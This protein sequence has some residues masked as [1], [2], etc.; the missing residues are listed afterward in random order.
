MPKLKE[1]LRRGDISV[2]TW[3]TIGHPDVVEALSTLPLDWLVFDMEHAPLDISLLEIMIMGTRGSNVEPIVR[4]SWNDM[5]AIKR[6]LDLGFRGLMIPYVNTREEAESAVKYSRYPPKGV[7]GYGPRRAIMYGAYGAQSSLEYYRGF[8]KEL[9]LI[10]QIE[11]ERAV[12]QAEDIASVDGV[13]VLFVGPADLSISLSAPLDYGSPRFVDALKEV[14]RACEKQGKIP[15]IH[16]IDVQ[17]ARRWI[18]MGF[19]FISI[20]TDI[21]M[22]RTAVISMLGSLG[23]V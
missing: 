19:R 14:L 9:V 2:G 22:L 21:D 15:G 11:S 7:R 6:T 23:R 1:I 20:S 13:D 16:A 17:Q 8:E 3:I 10:V 12:K 5:V 4:V 18:D